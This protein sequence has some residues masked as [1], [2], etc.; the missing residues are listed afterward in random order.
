M[1]TGWCPPPPSDV[2]WF[3]NPMN[4]IIISAINHSYG[5]YV[6]QLSDSELGHHLAGSPY[7]VETTIR[8]FSQANTVNSSNETETAQAAHRGHQWGT[9]IIQSWMTMPKEVAEFYGL[10]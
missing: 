2:C 8:I 6:H 9:A 3:I 1:G 4:T 7:V 5:S 10:S